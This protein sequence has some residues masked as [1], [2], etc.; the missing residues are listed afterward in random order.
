MIQTMCQQGFSPRT[1]QNHLYEVPALA[2]YYQRS[3]DHLKVDD[4]KSISTI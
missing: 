4:S 3:P 1:Q 2:L